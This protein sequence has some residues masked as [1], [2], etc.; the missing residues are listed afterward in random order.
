MPSTIVGV[1]LERYP[2]HIV[3]AN[4]IQIL[5]EEGMTANL[6]PIGATLTI[7]CTPQGDKKLAHYIRVNPDRVFDALEALA[8]GSDDP[9]RPTDGGQR[10]SMD[11]AVSPGT[12]RDGRHHDPQSPPIDPIF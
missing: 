4:G 12:R 1:L 8:A 11:E 3:L 2:D 10:Q 5:L 9:A 7:L 6:L